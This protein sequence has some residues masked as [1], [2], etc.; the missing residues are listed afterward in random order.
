MVI[1]TISL[2]ESLGHPHL[3]ATHG[4]ANSVH[5]RMLLRQVIV[6]LAHSGGIAMGL[7][8]QADQPYR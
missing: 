7:R 5:W 4:A 1:Q 8:K 6:Q 3:I 2:S